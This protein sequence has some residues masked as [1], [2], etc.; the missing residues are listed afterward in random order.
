[1]F[2]DGESVE[3][4]VVLGTDAQTVTNQVHVRQNT[5]AIDDGIASGW[6]VKSWGEE[7]QWL[8]CVS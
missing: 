3:E 5:V 7:S 8:V 2:P 4:H 1:M 6:C